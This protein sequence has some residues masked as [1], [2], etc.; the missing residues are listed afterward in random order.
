VIA[1]DENIL[2]SQ[3]E[4]L[5]G[6]K[7]RI[8]QIG[9]DIGRKGMQDDE[10]IPLLISLRRSTFFTRDRDFYREALRN[11]L[12]CI[13]HLNVGPL[14]VADYVRRFLRHPQF[15]TW[16]QR[17]GTVV[18]VQSTGIVGWLPKARQVVR[19]SW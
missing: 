13:V 18:R 14:E 8:C 11:N 9:Y 6:R 17:R 3:R 1:L 12:Y 16:S 10:I 2:V 4:A 19:Y 5:L 7:S 15:R